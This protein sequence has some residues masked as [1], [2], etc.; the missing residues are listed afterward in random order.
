MI[1]RAC[2]T[3]ATAELPTAV[4]HTMHSKVRDSEI[5]AFMEAALAQRVGGGEAA[6]E[7]A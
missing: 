1:R 2:G 3:P 6:G 4:E 7:A 5:D